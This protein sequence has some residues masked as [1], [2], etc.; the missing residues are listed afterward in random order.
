MNLKPKY[1]LD[2]VSY[3]EDTA[4]ANQSRYRVPGGA[5]PPGLCCA[6]R[7]R[8]SGRSACW[9][10]PE[11]PYD[12]ENPE[13]LRR[14][15]GRFPVVRPGL[16]LVLRTQSGS[17][18]RHHRRGPGDQR[19]SPGAAGGRSDHRAERAAVSGWLAADRLSS[20]GLLPV[21]HGRQFRRHRPDRPGVGVPAHGPHAGQPLRQE[22]CWV[23]GWGWCSP[24][25]PPPGARTSW[26][27]F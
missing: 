19:P 23:W 8:R 16:R 21:L 3:L 10:R 11:R 20:A 24:R 14:D 15:H 2:T 5:L 26:P 4:I 25:A 13:K 18:G 22:P 6:R 9:T 7:T 27:G 1:R 12:P 17:H